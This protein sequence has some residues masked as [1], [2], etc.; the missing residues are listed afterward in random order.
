VA[1]PYLDIV[2]FHR[3]T[4]LGASAAIAV[5]RKKERDL[6]EIFFTAGAIQ[7]IDARSPADL[8]VEENMTWKRLCKRS[9]IRETAPDLFYWDEDVWQALRSMRLRMGLMM[10]GT[11]LLIGLM[12]AWGSAQLK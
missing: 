2:S 1:K 7:P 6:R 9:V 3:R 4:I 10:L 11:I 8:G 12:I 5:M